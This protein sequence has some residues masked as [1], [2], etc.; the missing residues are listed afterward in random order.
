MKVQVQGRVPDKRRFGGGVKVVRGHIYYTAISCINNTGVILDVIDKQ[1]CVTE[2]PSYWLQAADSS[3]AL[4]FYEGAA[5]AA[6]S[7][8]ACVDVF[9]VSQGMVCANPDPDQGS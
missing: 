9:A 6:A 1:E 8:G 5:V 7:I 2:G 4:R 3:E